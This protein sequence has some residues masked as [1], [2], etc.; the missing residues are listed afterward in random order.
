MNGICYLILLLFLGAT[1]IWLSWRILIFL[2]LAG[3][4]ALIISIVA[5]WTVRKK[6]TIGLQG[7]NSVEKGQ[8]IILTPEMLYTGR[9]P[10][11]RISLDF[12]SENC[13]TGEHKKTVWN[14]NRRKT[15][16]DIGTYCGC[17][18]YRALKV[19][20][21]DWFGLVKIPIPVEVKKRVL[22]MPET[23]PVHVDEVQS[24]SLQEDCQ[25]YAPD[26][27][28]Q[29]R[30]ETFQIREYVPGDNINQIHWKLSSKLG[31]LYVKDASFPVDHSLMLFYDRGVKYTDPACADA[32][33]EAFTSVCQEL[34]DMGMPFRLFWNED[35]IEEYEVIST[36][37]L[38]EAI[39]ALLSCGRPVS[40]ASAISLFSE[41]KTVPEGSRILYFAEQFPEDLAASSF[42]QVFVVSD[43][44]EEGEGIHITRPEKVKE[45]IREI[46]WN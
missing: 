42:C 15:W 16:E 7:E 5:A 9:M 39:T 2:C 10:L 25:E 13:L 12:Y 40:D 3:M 6:I 23:F 44:E 21:Y 1:G 45:A 32:L 8:T 43:R 24:F 26:K 27:K 20:L 29:D 28:G 4:L 30:T 36:E 41:K 17:M 38:P 22:I 19:W 33:M 14:L 31:N 35:G 34:T 18:D 37:Q 11:G 46:I